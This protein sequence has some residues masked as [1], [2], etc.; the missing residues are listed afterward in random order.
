MLFIKASKRTSLHANC[1][2]VCLTGVKPIY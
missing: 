2:S 1:V